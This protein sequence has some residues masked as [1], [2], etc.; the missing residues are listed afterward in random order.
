MQLLPEEFS[1]PPLGE[2][3]LLPL[4]REETPGER[5]FAALPAP[6]LQSRGI[7]A[8]FSVLL[9]SST[10]QPRRDL[11]GGS[12]HA[13]KPWEDE[14]GSPESWEGSTQL[15]HGAVEGRDAPG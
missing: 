7:F 4:V 9:G 11:G 14:W 8:L 1:S 5:I 13:Q 6:A 2:A 3:S 10:P 12:S 15:S